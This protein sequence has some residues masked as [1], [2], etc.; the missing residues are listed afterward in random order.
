MDWTKIILL[1]TMKIQTA[2]RT[3]KIPVRVM[4]IVKMRVQKIIQ[5]ERRMT[6]PI[7]TPQEAQIRTK[8]AMAIQII[9]RTIKI[10]K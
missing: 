2:V 7:L 1:K 10:R 5:M 6:I 8:I 9:A 3:L 4:K